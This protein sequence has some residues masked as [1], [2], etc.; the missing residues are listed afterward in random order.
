MS[1][2]V[3]ELSLFNEVDEAVFDAFTVAVVV[4]VF[5]GVVGVAFL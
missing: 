1:F 5:V 4:V 2:D 3:I